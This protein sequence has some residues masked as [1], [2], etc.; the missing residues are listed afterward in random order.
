MNRVRA[1]RRFSP[2]RVKPQVIRHVDA[3]DHQ[4]V[5][6]LLDFAD[7]VRAEPALAG[8]NPARLQRASERAGQSAGGGRNEVVQRRRVRLVH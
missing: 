3:T 8:R 2:V 6:F 1:L 4:H 7:G 5:A